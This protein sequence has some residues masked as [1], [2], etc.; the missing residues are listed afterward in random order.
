[1]DLELQQIQEL[2]KILEQSRLKKI[3]IK[4]GDFEVTLE[5]EG[6]VVA[7]PIHSFSHPVRTAHEEPLSDTHH[8]GHKKPDLEGKFVV[9]PMVGTFYASSAPDQPPFV[10]VGDRVDEDTV[11]CIIEAMKV[12]NEVKAGSKGIIAEVL[13]D[14]AQP[15]EFGAKLFRIE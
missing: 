8:R 7:A 12:M 3:V 9:S 4:R 5:K 13:V 1:M 2:M 11:V 6:E 15:L 14:N 10:K